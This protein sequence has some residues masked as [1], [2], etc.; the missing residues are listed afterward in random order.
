MKKALIIILSVFVLVLISAIILPFL[1]KDKIIAKVK[2]EVNNNLNAKVDFGNFDVTIISSFPNFTFEIQNVSIANINEFEGDT[3]AAIKDLSITVD[4]MSVIKGKQYNIRSITIEN[5]RILAKVLKDGKANWDITKPSADTT[6]TAPKEE[7]PFKMSLNNFEIIGSRIIYDDAQMGFYM[8]LN[9]MN[10]TLSG[11][12]TD[13]FTSLETNTEIKSMTMIYDGVPYFKNVNTSIDADLD[14]DLKNSK[15]TF[16]ENE[17]RLNELY[18]VLDGWVSMP[19]EDIDMDLKFGAKKTEFKNIL[20]LIPAIY[21][22]DFEKVKTSGKLALEGKMKGIYNDKNMPAF[23]FRLLVENAMFQYP[24]LPKSV[25]NINIDIVADNKDG[26]PD[27]TLID[28]KKFH[29]EMAGN[30]V[31]VKMVIKTP[32]S[33]PNIDGNIK[34]KI[35]LASVK[36][37]I[38]MDEGESMTGIITSDVQLKGKMS[39][40][41][42]ERY[43]EFKAAGQFTIEKM[44]YTTKDMPSTI[45]NILKLNFSPQFVELVSFDSKLGKSDIQAD[46]RIDNFMQYVFKDSLLTGKFT[47]KSNSFDLNEWMSDEDGD[48]ETESSTDTA[49]MAVIEVP[50]NIDFVLNSTIGKLLYENYGITDLSGQIIVRNSRVDMSN[51]K[52]NMMGGS[53]AMSGSYDSKNIKKPQVDFALDISNFDI[54]TTYKTFN[55]VQ[56]IAAIAKQAKGSFSTQ[57]NFKADLDQK[58]EPILT[59]LTGGGNLT[60][61]NVTISNFEPI[62][63]M[64]GELKMD[65]FKTMSFENLNISYEFIDG[66][67]RVKPFNFKSGNV[68]GIIDGSTGFDQSIDYKWTL[69]IPTSEMP[70]AAKQHVNGLISQANTKLGSSM[71]MGDKVKLDVLFGGTVTNPT[72]KTGMKGAVENVK[73]QVKEVVKEKVQEKVQE[74]KEDV[75]AK[76]REEADKIM[77]DA[78]AQAQKIRNE[79]SSAAEKVKSEGYKQADDLESKAKNPIEKAAAKKAAEKLRKESDKKAQQINDEAAQKA[80][81]VLDVARKQAD[82]KLK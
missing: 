44:N 62:N 6:T 26:K 64:A 15:Y 41:E 42:K 24:D 20:S 51:L 53:I 48:P 66:R 78:E 11:D 61:K 63:K 23:N 12:F 2:E 65:K 76:A 5:A 77:K 27:N 37:F 19:A 70:A 55:T 68:S 73:E 72:V 82:E 35:D 28:I 57:L 3:L 34:A 69:D 52:M 74:V 13:D 7:A 40:I 32:E 43:D 10:H 59:S 31:D 8:N 58:M 38:P 9:G 36:D 50:S 75:K 30:P 39:S 81:N 17:F 14:A 79:A 33:D 22:K 80:N 45:I 47:M 29:V 56:K 21:S 25:N 71:S 16:K 46:G 1:F 54:P 60:T 67:V 18:L 4:L 49:A